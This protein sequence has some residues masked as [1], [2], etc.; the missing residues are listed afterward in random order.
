[1]VHSGRDTPESLNREGSCN[2]SG[3]IQTN[4][5][6]RIMYIM[7]NMN[8]TLNILNSEFCREPHAVDET[9]RIFLVSQLVFHVLDIG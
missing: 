6:V 8:R 7:L 1:M 9:R 3:S 4:P 5:I 2:C